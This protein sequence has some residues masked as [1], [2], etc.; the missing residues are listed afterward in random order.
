MPLASI[1]TRSLHVDLLFL[2]LWS[3]LCLFIEFSLLRVRDGTS[4]QV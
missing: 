4:D 3:L 1:I 2:H